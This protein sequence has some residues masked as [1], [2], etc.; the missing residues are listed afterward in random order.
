MKRREI[1][2]QCICTS[3]NALVQFTHRIDVLIDENNNSYESGLV[4]IQE[5]LEKSVI[6]GCEGLVV[7]MLPST[8][9]PSRGS[10]RSNSWGKL[11][12]DYLEGLADSF[13]LIPIGAYWGNGR[14]AGWFS[15]FLLGVND[16]K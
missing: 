7:K 6:V 15:P 4:K 2:D 16:L 5:L 11:K 10:E 13:D 14:K 9:I 8:Y 12:K 1:M 3:I